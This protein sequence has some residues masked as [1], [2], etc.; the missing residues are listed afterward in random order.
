MSAIVWSGG[1][2]AVTTKF[3]PGGDLD[4]AACE[5]YFAWQVDSGVNGLIVS[6]SLGEGSTLSADEKI[7]LVRIARGASNGRVP[8]VL[9]IAEAVSARAVHLAH[10]AE[11]AHADGVMLLPPMMYH[12]SRA[13]V[14]SW[15]RAVADASDLPLMVYNNPVSY[16]TDVDVDMLRYLAE[17][18][19]IRAVKESSGDVRRVIRIR[20]ALGDRLSIMAGVDNLAFESAVAGA[21]GWVA[22][23]VDAF[24]QETVAIWQIVQAGRIEEALRLYGWFTPLLELDVSPQLVQNIKLQEAIVGVG[25]ENVRP[26][27][28]KLEGAERRRVEQVIQEATGTRPA[29]PPLAVAA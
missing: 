13:E 25:N 14:L 6:G 26:P 8:V 17:H 20:N 29:L 4:T 2:P 11:T 3:T 15:F 12:A 27:R 16:G 10:R 19:R 28:R 23:L 22:G 5:R 21:D 24:P 9:S 18:R 7:E 1:F